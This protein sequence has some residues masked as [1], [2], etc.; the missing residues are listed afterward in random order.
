MAGLPPIDSV[1]LLPVLRSSG[2][3]KLP[4]QRR[5]SLALGSE[6]TDGHK[7]GTTVAGWIAEDQSGAIFKLILGSW[8]Q[9]TWV[10]PHFPNAST[11]FEPSDFVENCTIP[12]VKIGCL[13][14]V[15]LLVVYARLS[16]LC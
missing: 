10:G 15:Q 13:L 16:Q 1:S 8:D 11:N 2:D 12:G 6:P 7:N 14:C 5:R 9:S 3:G 4:Q